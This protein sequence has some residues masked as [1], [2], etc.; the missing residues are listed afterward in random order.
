MGIETVTSSD[1]ERLEGKMDKMATAIEK[2]V[3][4]EERQSNHK[5]E[6][7]KQAAAIIKLEESLARLHSRVDKY[8]YLASGAAFIV[9]IMFEIARFIFKA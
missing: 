6:L 9:M 3:L 2:L 8:S 1:F 5:I 7:D 4:V